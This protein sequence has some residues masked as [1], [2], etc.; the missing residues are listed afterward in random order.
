MLITQ[1]PHEQGID[2]C[3]PNLAGYSRQKKGVSANAETPLDQGIHE[4][5]KPLLYRDN[6]LRGPETVDIAVGR[7]VELAGFGQLGVDR[8]RALRV[9]R[10]LIRPFR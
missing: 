6:L 7:G 10:T 4:S 5:P 9:G 8:H 2:A 3:L 1:P